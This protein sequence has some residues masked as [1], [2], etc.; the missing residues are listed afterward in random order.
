VAERLLLIDQGNTRLKW[1]MA[2]AGKLDTNSAGYGDFNAFR[3][4]LS[5]DHAAPQAVLLA[6][7]ADPE[8]KQ[9]LADFCRRHWK[10]EPR[11]LV[12]KQEQGGVRNAYREP[13]TLGV[14]RWLAIV[15]AANHHGMPVVIWDLGTAS[16]LD[17]V[18][19]QGRHLGG[20]I[21]P[22]P[23]TMLRALQ[24]DTRL[25]VPNVVPGALPGEAGTSGP[26][27]AP[28]TSTADCIGRGVL[29]AQLGALNQFMR[30]VSSSGGTPPRLVVTGGAAEPILP[31]LDFPIIHDPWLVFRG[32]LVE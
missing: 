13:A 6:G 8:K 16:T 1:G 17:A 9:A 11:L 28:G 7:V 23:A 5:E 31:L 25:S 18:D 14:D 19:A 30:S 4:A 21:Y 32:M 15:G 27:V 12:S 29:A 2:A 10:I 24:R 20:L 22:G 3:V 26:G